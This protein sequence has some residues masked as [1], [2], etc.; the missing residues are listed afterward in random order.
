MTSVVEIPVTGFEMPITAVCIDNIRTNLKLPGLGKL[1]QAFQ[2]KGYTLADKMLTENCDNIN[3]VGM[4]IGENESQIIPQHEVLFGNEPKSMMSITSHGVLLSGRIQRMLDNIGMLPYHDDAVK[5]T[6]VSAHKRSFECMATIAGPAEPTHDTLQC[7]PSLERQSQGNVDS[8]ISGVNKQNPSI[9]ANTSHL[10]YKQD[11]HI[12]DA[13]GNIN[14]QA[15]NKAVNHAVQSNQNDN[16]MYEKSQYEDEIVESDMEAVE[17][18]LESI[19]RDESGRV[20]I[21][22]LWD[23]QQCE[24]LANNF[25]LAKAI[26]KSNLHKLQKSPNHLA[27]YDKVIQDQLA[28]GAIEKIDNLENFIKE[29]PNCSFLPHM[30]VFRENHPSTPCRVVFLAN[31]CDRRNNANSISHNQAMKAGINFNKPIAASLTELRMNR[32]ILNLDIVKAYTNIGL[33]DIDSEKL[34]FLWFTNISQD[35]YE[36]CAYTCKRLP[37]GIRPSAALLSI[38]LYKMLILDAEHDEKPLKELKKELFSLFY[39][40]NSSIGANTKEELRWKYEQLSGIFEPY[41]FYLQQMSTNDTE[42]Q[43]IIDAKCGI[44]TPAKLKMFG[45]LWDRENDI[46]STCPMK[47][48]RSACSKRSILSSINSNFDVFGINSPLLNRARIFMHRLQCNPKLSWDTKIDDELYKEWVNI[49]I[50]VEKTPPIE[51]PRFIG[52][53]DEE[54]ELLC[55]TDASK[56]MYGITLHLHELSTGK[57]SFL[58]SKNHIV[59]TQLESKSIP[60]LEFHS[61][62]L[63]VHELINYAEQLAGDNSYPP[64]KISSLKLF[65]DSACC[66]GWLKAG[67][68]RLDKMTKVSPFVKNRLEKI[69]KLCNKRPVQFNFT[70]GL[71]NPADCVTRCL[72]YAQLCKSTYLLGPPVKDL[73]CKTSDM[74]VRLPPADI[75]DDSIHGLQTVVE[76]PNVQAVEFDRFSSF[77]KLFSGYKIWLKFLNKLKQRTNVKYNRS[78][79]IKSEYQIQQDTYN[80]LVRSDQMEHF[81]EE[82]EFLNSKKQIPNRNI[83]NIVTRLN[84]FSDSGILKVRSKFEKWSDHKKYNYPVLL[85]KKSKLTCL[86]I[87]HLHENKGHA[88]VYSVLNELRKRYYV[89][90]H[91]STV[92]S[93]IKSCIVCRRVNSRSIQINQNSYRDFRVDPDNVCYRNCFVDHFGPYTVKI[94]G[95]KRKVWVLLITCMWSRNINLK[96]CLDMTTSAFLR[97]L[98][99]HIFEHGTMSRLMGDLGSS[100][101]AGFNIIRG[102]LGK[103]DVEQFLVDNGIQTFNLDQ[104]PKGNS[105]LASLAESCVKLAKRMINGSIGKQILD[106]FDFQFALCQTT[107]MVNKRPIAFL[108]SLRDSDESSVL[109]P[110]ITPESLRNGHCLATLNIL[111]S[112]SVDVDPDWQPCLDSDFSLKNAFEK[113]NKNRQNLS[114]IYQNEFMANLTRQATNV[115]GRYAKVKHD[116][117]TVGDVVLLV[118]P[119]TKAINFPMGKVIS[120][121]ENSCNEVTNAIILKG[122]KEK[123]KRHVKSLIL[124]IKNS[125]LQSKSQ[126][127]GQKSSETDTG[128]QN[129]SHRNGLNSAEVKVKPT[130]RKAADKCYQQLAEL[131]DHDLI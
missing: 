96:L 94:R 58:A 114:A 21:R 64:M 67:G 60:S 73:D 1:V 34:L 19:T 115:K 16:F 127:V 87:K 57:I 24:R 44:E 35:N 41:Q 121:T 123:V 130:R 51:I 42:L 124:L 84:V 6:G 97:A 117:L 31:L 33:Y 109:P 17:K 104:I 126:S 50:Q 54:Y 55:C 62:S 7:K 111:P 61:I 28:K 65:T 38:V 36:I 22:L 56:T 13:N 78:H 99:E 74:N 103:S 11:L 48:N 88:G 125:E 63:G 98:Q 40:D 112:F 89:P 14:E 76:Q 10:N 37:F 45:M 118:E 82:I 102:M 15:L 53:R 131:A 52:S 91:F 25:G 46:I 110:A 49:C 30:G 32:Y 43:S 4:I 26:L 83:P 80:L 93:V 27:M 59:N 86:I 122:N 70:N 92:K 75:S 71:K 12:F 20:F 105:E 90:C 81:K 39:V 72:S 95:E 119:H 100:I 8:S 128:G 101:T 107:C 113:L 66:L 23:E 18:A 3:N 79:I 9:V 47:L 77:A 69:L 106:V 29:H 5:H 129:V 68:I 85:S 116:K 120:V 2:K 108:D